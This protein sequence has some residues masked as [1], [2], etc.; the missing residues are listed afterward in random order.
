MK[1]FFG[2]PLA[3]LNLT[4][5]WRQF[6]LFSAGIGFAVTLMFVQYGFRNALLDSNVLLIEKFNADLVLVSRAHSTL[7]IREAFSRHRIA[8]AASVPGV[9]SAYPLYIEYNLSTI[10][11]TQPA[12]QRE[13]RRTIRVIGVDPDANLLKF[14]ELASPSQPGSLAGELKVQGRALYDRKSKRPNEDRS[15]SV[16]GPLAPGI[17]TELAGQQIHLVGGFDLG[18]DFGAEGTLIVSAE[19]FGEL[20]RRPYVLG[21]PLDEVEVGLVKLAKGADR[22]EVKRA[23]QAVFAEGDVDVLTK[24][25]L[26]D[27]ERDFW[28]DQT[29]IGFVF[30]FGMVMGFV[31]GM[32]ICYQVLS[33]DVADHLAE[34]ATLKAIGYPNRYLSKVVLQEAMFLAAAGFVPGL[35]QGL[36]LYE[37]LSWMTD[38]PMR[39]TPFR[40]GFILFLTMAMCAGS[41]LLAL[42]KAQAVDPAEVF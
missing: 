7:A 19:T 4:N 10:G 21:G 27:R 12:D 5:D 22:K 24:D 34:Y 13:P 40:V 29:P 26:M 33:S 18:S 31:V 17:D 28:L 16:F 36:V 37:L 42:R 1:R 30:G 3:W 35:V 15:R 39:L 32:V 8:Q 20:L 23:L 9:A 14:P 2:V 25:E 11:T 41:G 6:A 38:L